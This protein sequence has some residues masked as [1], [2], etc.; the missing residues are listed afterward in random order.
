MFPGGVF[1][2]GVFPEGLFAGSPP[3]AAALPTLLRSVRQL[4]LDLGLAEQIAPLYL[5]Q[6]PPGMAPPYVVLQETGSVPTFNT[7]PRYIETW[8]LRFQ[9][10]G[11]SES[12]A[13]DLGDRMDEA[14]RFAEPPPYGD[15]RPKALRRTGATLYRDP[16]PW[17]DNR[18][19]VRRILTYALPVVRRK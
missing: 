4:W 6:A 9:A 12:Q 7:G 8:M 19:K 10:V 3:S 2:S 15:E 17:P 18:P 5:D 1:P 14:L 16:P 13:V 11:R